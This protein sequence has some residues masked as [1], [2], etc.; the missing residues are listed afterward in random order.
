MG[1]EG[2]GAGGGER[3]LVPAP[4]TCFLPLP[5]LESTGESSHPHSAYASHPAGLRFSLR[6]VICALGHF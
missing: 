1:G 5:C 4:W 6:W 2:A 3:F